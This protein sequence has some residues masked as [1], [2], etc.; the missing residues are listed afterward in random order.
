M[1]RHVGIGIAS[2]MLLFVLLGA[3]GC[4]SAKGETL[5]KKRDYAL[6]M[7]SSVLQ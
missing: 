6:E 4:M 1:T 5:Q 7:Q 2:V 3:G